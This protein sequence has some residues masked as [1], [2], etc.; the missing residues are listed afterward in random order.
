M[1][2]GRP[3]QGRWIQKEDDRGN[4]IFLSKAD[5]EKAALASA[6]AKAQAK[7]VETYADYMGMDDEERLRLYTRMFGVGLISAGAL[8]YFTK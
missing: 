4:P 5:Y 2:D 3:H 6:S 7:P 1:K 8:Y